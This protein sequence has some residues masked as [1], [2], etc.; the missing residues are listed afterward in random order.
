MWLCQQEVPRGED[1]PDTESV[2]EPDA[3]LMSAANVWED[4]LNLDTQA[5][6]LDVL[7]KRVREAIDL[8]LEVQESAIK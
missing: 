4:A 7:M 5:K 8:C 1:K 3:Q 2:H 6:S